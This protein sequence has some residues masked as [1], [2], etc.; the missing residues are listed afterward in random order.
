MVRC[1]RCELTGCKICDAM[2]LKERLGRNLKI[3][4]PPPP[5]L[6]PRFDSFDFVCACV[7]V[8]A[9][10]VIKFTREYASLVGETTFFIRGC[11]RGDRLASFV[12]SSSEGVY[13]NL[14]GTTM[15]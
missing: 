3:I 9:R 5:P 10:H 7:R 8:C 14:I 4:D 13:K 15:M 11:P 12:A 6:S 2:L 1:K